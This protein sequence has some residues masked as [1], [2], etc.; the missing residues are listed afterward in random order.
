[1]QFSSSLVLVRGGGDLA[2]GVVYRLHR[3]GFPGVVTELPHPLA[4]RR[5][6]AFG[7]A[8]Y[9]GQVTV[10]GIVGRRVPDAAA[11][12]DA[13]HG[14]EVAVLVDREG[15]SLKT[16]K[17][18]IVV[19]AR[20]A[21]V[22]LG[23][24]MQ[25]APLVIGLG[26]GFTAGMDCHAVVETKR[27]HTLG[28]VFWQGSAAPDTRMPEG[29]AGRAGERVLRA[30][31]GGRVVGRKQ[32]GDQIAEG[33]IIAEIVADGEGTGALLTAPFNGVLR[34]LIHPATPVTAG[35]KVGDLDP[36]GEREY[37]F[38]ISDKALAVGGGV[39]EAVLV[40]LGRV[41]GEG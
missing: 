26:P 4:V 31:V 16:L 34:G 23:T 1:M 19:D 5:A 6:V 28:R 30:P 2:S 10:E 15:Q 37:C 24:T 17:P 14:G 7:E 12:R 20:L 18:E 22:N 40:W 38:S 33:E 9:A 13:L 39:L 8:V 35:M 25:D 11:A 32:I 27:G 3:A 21:K 29:V 41:R 36:R